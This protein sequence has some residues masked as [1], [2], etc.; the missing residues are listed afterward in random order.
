[1]KTLLRFLIRLLTTTNSHPPVSMCM[2]PLELEEGEPY[3]VLS[4]SDALAPSTIEHLAEMR[5]KH[6]QNYGDYQ[7][8]TALASSMREWSAE[9]T[10]I[11]T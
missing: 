5:L 1:M 4:A 10:E 9:H 6:Q 11:T 2:V 3:L 7:A 8:L